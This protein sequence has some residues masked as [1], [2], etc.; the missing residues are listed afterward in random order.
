MQHDTQNLTKLQDTIYKFKPGDIITN[1]KDDKSGIIS[2][3][4]NLALLGST[5]QVISVENGNY[6]LKILDTLTASPRLDRNEEEIIETLSKVSIDYLNF[7]KLWNKDEVDAVYNRALD[8]AKKQEE[9]DKIFN[10]RIAEIIA[11]L[12]PKVRKFFD[13]SKKKFGVYTIEQTFKKFERDIPMAEK[14]SS[15]EY[16]PGSMETLWNMIDVDKLKLAEDYDSVHQKLFGNYYENFKTGTMDILNEKNISNPKNALTVRVLGDP[17]LH[18][19]IGKYLSKSIKGGRKTKKMRGGNKFNPGDIITQFKTPTLYFR[20]AKEWMHNINTNSATWKVISIENG[21]YKLQRLDTL[22]KSPLLEKDSPIYIKA[23][24]SKRMIDNGEYRLWDEDDVTAVYNRL[25]AKVKEED[26]ADDRAFKI[27]NKEMTDYFKQ[28][29]SIAETA[30][31]YNLTKEEIL[32]ALGD[33]KLKGA[34][35]YLD[36]KKELL[37]NDNL[38]RAEAEYL[39][40][41]TKKAG[42]TKTKKTGTKSKKGRKIKI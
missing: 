35:D 14:W 15:S 27:Y 36:V 16:G 7:Y 10:A 17:N 24:M 9:K 29:N 21:D 31:Q 2:A 26:E 22:T 30:D 40:R 1:Y 33:D 11:E 32:D 4:A 6:T 39:K 13:N 28:C 5:W 8:A 3:K 37:T 23:T 20:P 19:T 42:G 18:R 41:S 34:T 25:L 38:P 12:T